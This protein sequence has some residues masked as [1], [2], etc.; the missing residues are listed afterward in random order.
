MKFY[1][2]NIFIKLF[3]S[4]ICL[5]IFIYIISYGIFEIKTNKNYF[6]TIFLIFY[7]LASFI[8]CNIAFWI[9]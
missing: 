6:G 8:F 7:S 1:M 2:N 4:F 3:F 5:C 9:E